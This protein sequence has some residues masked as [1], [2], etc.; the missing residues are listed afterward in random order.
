MAKVLVV[1]NYD[2]FT[3]NLV[4]YLA[5][6]GAADSQRALVDFD[7]FLHSTRLTGADGF[8]CTADLNSALAEH[9][10][11]HP[12][13]VLSPASHH[14]SRV[15]PSHWAIDHPSEEEH[16]LLSRH[17]RSESHSEPPATPRPRRT[18]LRREIS[19]RLCMGGRIA[20]VLQWCRRNRPGVTPSAIEAHRDDNQTR[21]RA[22][23]WTEKHVTGTRCKKR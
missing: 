16:Q 1:D 12:S 9:I 6:L 5:E 18:K 2:S 14:H 7:R 20:V 19:V 11:D 21:M 4:Q 15:L 3:Y 23:G 17:Q 8:I 22:A 13:L 10:L